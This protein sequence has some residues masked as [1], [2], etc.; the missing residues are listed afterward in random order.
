M[1]T[2]KAVVELSM[3]ELN[4]LNGMLE[5]HDVPFTANDIMTINDM[6]DISWTLDHTLMFDNYSD[7][8][9]TVGF[10]N[11]MLMDICFTA[12]VGEMRGFYKGIRFGSYDECIVEP[13]EQTNCECFVFLKYMGMKHVNMVY[14]SSILKSN[15]E[16]TIDEENYQEYSYCMC[17]RICDY[18]WSGIMWFKWIPF[19]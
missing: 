2:Y 11:N 10:R 12:E 18:D 7:R 5:N 8:N 16:R 1:E 19:K 13:G 17:G 3:R 14:Y 9:I 4:A 15:D 6:C